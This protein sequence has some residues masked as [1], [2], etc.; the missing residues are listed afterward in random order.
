RFANE[1]AKMATAFSKRGLPAEEG[2]GWLLPRIIGHASALDLLLSSRTI[3]GREAASLGMVHFALPPGD[4]LPAALE[5][6]RELAR[7]CSPYAMATIKR[8]I[9]DDWTRTAGE[10]RR[11]ARDLMHQLRKHSDFREGVT[12]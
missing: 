5:Y 1:E 2:I 8:Q 7:S 10:A 3:T 6:G 4:V 9:Y 11:E 12:S